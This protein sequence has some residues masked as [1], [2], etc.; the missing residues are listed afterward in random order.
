MV[1]S[2][3]EAAFA[4]GSLSVVRGVALAELPLGALRTVDRD[5]VIDVR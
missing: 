3:P 2:S 4:A 5:L 1:V